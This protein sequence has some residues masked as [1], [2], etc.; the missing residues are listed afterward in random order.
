[1]SATYE[2]VGISVSSPSVLPLDSLVRNFSGNSSAFLMT[3]EMPLA[4]M[5][6]D[7]TPIMASPGCSL[8]PVTSLLAGA[9]MAVTQP[10]SDGALF[11]GGSALTRYLSAG[12][13][14]VGVHDRHRALRDDIVDGHERSINADAFVIRLPCA[15]VL[16]HPL[17]NPVFVAQALL[18]VAPQMF[19]FAAILK[20]P[21]V[22][23]QDVA[24][25]IHIALV[26]ERE[27]FLARR[28]HRVLEGLDFCVIHAGL[29]IRAC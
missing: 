2:R 25:D 8:V 19:F 1:M 24:V 29:R 14:F 7:V 10:E 26:G 4:W 20:N 17:R 13:S 11:T 6:E 21:A 16:V 5:P 12:D 3:S 23:M 15:G 22:R 27:R 28:N 18:R 9:M